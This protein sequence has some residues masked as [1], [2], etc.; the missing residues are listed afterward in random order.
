[1]IRSGVRPT[2][3]GRTDGS[4]T[5]TANPATRLASSRSA[6]IRGAP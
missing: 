2:P 1:M 4:T 3:R 6:V 5:G